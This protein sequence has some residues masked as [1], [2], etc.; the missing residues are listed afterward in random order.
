MPLNRKIEELKKRR[1]VV[2]MGGG[3]KAIEKQ[4]ALGKMTARERILALLDADSF[5]EYDL[6]A[7]HEARDFNMDK[8]VLH[9][10]GVVIGTGT[11]S[12]SPISY[13]FV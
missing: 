12:G 13:N 2:Q 6:F 9:G 8:Q 4:Q 10:D 3:E 5:T 7:E 1:E 11:M